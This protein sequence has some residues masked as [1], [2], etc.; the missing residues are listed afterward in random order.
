MVVKK[1]SS[2]PDS[3]YQQLAGNNPSRDNPLD[4]SPTPNLKSEHSAKL[5]IF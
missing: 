3:D 5:V 4:N 1:R 2:R